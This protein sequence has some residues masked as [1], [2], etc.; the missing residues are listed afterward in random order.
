M[1]LKSWWRNTFSRTRWK[2]R[3][4]LRSAQQL[5]AFARDFCP[6][7]GSREVKIW[8]DFGPYR[9]LQKKDILEI[10]AW[11]WAPGP[12]YDV[13]TFDCENFVR[14][15][16]ARFERWWREKSDLKG[17]LGLGDIWLQKKGHE[18]AH[19]LLWFHD[20]DGNFIFIEGQSGKEWTGEIEKIYEIR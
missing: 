17:P 13:D 3:S 5:R 1:S 18:N 7:A 11:A 6:T 4:V 9:C 15:L 14:Q 19:E 20:Y 10:V 16:R 8:E 2:D 12:E